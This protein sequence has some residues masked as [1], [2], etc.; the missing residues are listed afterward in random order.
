MFSMGTVLEKQPKSKNI[1]EKAPAQAQ[2]QTDINP[3]QLEQVIT[4]PSLSTLTPS[5]VRTLQASHGNRFVSHLMRQA[6]RSLSITP[7]TQKSE[8]QLQRMVAVASADT[9]G[10]I[11]NLI[12]NAVAALS[13]GNFQVAASNGKT[14]YTLLQ[15]IDW[16][17]NIGGGPLFDLG[18]PA[19]QDI[20][21]GESLFIVE[22]G[23]VGSIGTYNGNQIAAALLDTQTGL[24]DQWKGI[25]NITSCYAGEGGA[26]S[27]AAIVQETL[28]NA[29]RGNEGFSKFDSGSVIVRGHP[30]TTFTHSTFGEKIFYVEPGKEKG[31]DKINKYY[32]NQHGLVLVKWIQDMA[33][34]LSGSQ[35]P[36]IQELAAY[37]AGITKPIYESMMQDMKNGG[38]VIEDTHS[39]EKVFTDKSK[40][41][42]EAM[43]GWDGQTGKKGV[44]RVQN[45]M[46]T[47]FNLMRDDKQK[48]HRSERD[49]LVNIFFSKLKT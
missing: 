24:P 45:E 13:M 7:V 16:A 1:V 29:Q 32:E 40:Q 9:M 15:H 3:H 17:L 47:A 44:V 4:N 31:A 33:Q 6:Q 36:E 35:D 22:H 11:K 28:D 26:Q 48:V 30:G 20:M 21:H 37:T 10:Q 34:K 39:A 27:V 41:L 38:I 46:Q 43:K 18:S 25:I 49:G 42:E 19:F 14:A 23:N 5:I 12:Q 8:P 2:S